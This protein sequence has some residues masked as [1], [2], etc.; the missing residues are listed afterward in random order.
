MTKIEESAFAGCKDLH[1]VY[2]TGTEAAWADISI[3]KDNEALAEA[4]L[5]YYSDEPIY[6]GTHWRY[7][8]GA[9]T[10]WKEN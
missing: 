1:A 4:T 2:Y 3:G 10:V 8:D 5:Y 6:D 9:P 7:V